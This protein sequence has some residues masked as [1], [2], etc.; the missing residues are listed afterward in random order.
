MAS[1]SAKQSFWVCILGILLSLVVSIGSSRVSLW[2]DELHTEWTISGPMSQLSPRAAAGNQSSAF[3]LTILPV[4]RTLTAAGVQ[5]EVALR[6]PS[7]LAVAAM[8][9]LIGTFGFYVRWPVEALVV[10]CFWLP[11]DWVQLFYATEARPYAA[12]QLLTLLSWA[13]VFTLVARCL[14]QSP[15]P[16]SIRLAL[17]WAAIGTLAVAFHATS[18]PAVAAAWCTVASV[19]VYK[20]QTRPLLVWGLLGVPVVAYFLVWAR[21]LDSSE[22]SPW[23]RRDNW[24]AFAGNSSL[25][26]LANLFPQLG[27][28]ATVVAVV[29]CATLIANRLGKPSEHHPQSSSWKQLTFWLFAFAT[30]ALAVWLLTR[31]EIFPLMHRRYA[32]ASLAPLALMAATVT[33]IPKNKLL[34]LTTA[35]L[36]IGGLLY[37]QGTTSVFRQGRL[38][39][40][41]RL[42]GWRQVSR[43]I[44]GNCQATDEVW[45]ASQLIE[46]NTPPHLS[47]TLD[48]YLSYPLRGLYAAKEI[49][50]ENVH[51][52]VNDPQQWAD[53]IFNANSPLGESKAVWVVYRG[54]ARDLDRRIAVLRSKPIAQDFD[55]QP[56]QATT[57]FGSVS[58]TQLTIMRTRSD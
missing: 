32:V 3:Y 1:V 11:L 2:L 24:N 30:P 14:S 49:D 15:K 40:W 26:D 42:E 28:L 5:P 31:Q 34:R 58:V 19:L 39:P 47:K 4:Y 13:I 36:V 52:L 29:L 18:L 16:F 53:Q 54:L 17:T 45:C 6:L 20:K 33:S 43:L 7:A 55:I 50:T 35:M 38:T 41:Q 27:F 23:S 44:D 51:A 10:G 22:S 12:V 46:G 48:Q 56:K 25:D 21:I 8:V 57:A 9:A 37:Q